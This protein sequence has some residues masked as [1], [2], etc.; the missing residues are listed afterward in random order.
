MKKAYDLAMD[1]NN[2]F[3]KKVDKDTVRLTLARWYGKVDRMDDG[4]FRTVTD[5]FCN[6]YN[7]ILNYSS[8]AQLMQELNHS[9]QK[10]KH[11]KVSSEV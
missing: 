11:S 2:I 10:S 1:L 4:Q 8:T 5:T 9:T 7:T 3:N 6:H